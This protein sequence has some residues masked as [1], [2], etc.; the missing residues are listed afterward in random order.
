M[1]PPQYGRTADPEYI[2]NRLFTQAILYGLPI[3]V[4]ALI[5]AVFQAVN[6][7]NPFL[8]A[9]G[10]GMVL[11]VAVVCLNAK[12][13]LAMRKLTV[14]AALV[15]TAMVLMT[16]LG[17]LSIGGSYLLT[18][19]V[20]YA[21]HF[22]G[23][24][25]LRAV[26]VN[27]A[28]CVAFALGILFGVL[29]AGGMRAVSLMQW[30]TYA[31]NFLF[32]NIVIVIMIRQTIARLER[33]LRMEAETHQELK[34]EF[35]ENQHLHNYLQES[36]NRYRTL[37]SMSPS[38]KL[39]FDID[40]LSFLETNQA[41]TEVYG[42][43]EAEFL[44]M[45]LTDIHLPE[46]VQK[47]I[48]RV[49]DANQ[50]DGALSTLRTR[51]VRKD[52]ALIEV[53]VLRTNI[54]FYGKKARLIVINDI[55][56]QIVQVNAIQKQNAKLKEIVHIQ[57]HLVRQPL[58]QI[59]ALTDLI[60]DEFKTEGDPRLLAALTESAKELDQLICRVVSESTDI[61]NEFEG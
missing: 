55:T 29:P 41:A 49:A 32:L 35:E 22:S 37:F 61:L 43:T 17:L 26:G 31:V 56:Q 28:V 50:T 11:A 9:F 27:V 59:M 5:P 7:G 40:T 39:I 3:A 45:K 36:E 18:C 57:S 13:S 53:E 10:P 23:K 42:Y 33:T 19:S 20:F 48:K 2:S 12:L 58:T 51:H 46:Q 60:A 52:G 15:I 14:A 34:N 44:N 16:K 8:V 54:E 6:R 25:A 21:L 38:A 24:F 47:L 4:L 30:I 1:Q